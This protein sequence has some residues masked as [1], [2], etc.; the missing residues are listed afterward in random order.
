MHLSNEQVETFR[1]EGFL[2]VSKVLDE[3]ERATL[4]KALERI[5]TK[6]NAHPER[7]HARFVKKSSDTWGCGDV[8]T[9][10]LYEE[11]LANYLARPDLLDGIKALL[12]TTDLRFWGGHALW[13]PD[14]IPYNLHWHR[15]GTPDLYDP[16]GRATHVQ[17]N[18]ALGPDSSFLAIPGSHRRALTTAETEAVTKRTTDVLPGEVV[19]H[20]EPGDV[21]FMNAWTLHRGRSPAGGGRRT[22]H[23]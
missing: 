18:T 16:S 17:F 4:L 2:V 14:R 8:F 15:D 10:E 11:A 21:V 20:C 9:P 5:R 6:V 23:F 19:A 3:D 12:R 13:S 22:L 1:K 7:Y